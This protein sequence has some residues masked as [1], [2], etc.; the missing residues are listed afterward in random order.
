MA[1]SHSSSTSNWYLPPAATGN[2]FTPGP[3]QGESEAADGIPF[4]RAAAAASQTLASSVHCAWMPSSSTSTP[5]SFCKGL[6]R[7]VPHFSSTGSIFLASARTLGNSGARACTLAPPRCSSSASLRCHSA[8]SSVHWSSS[9]LLRRAC[10]GRYGAK[11]NAFLFL[12]CGPS[13]ESWASSFSSRARCAGL[14]SSSPSSSSSSSS[15]SSS[16]SSASSSD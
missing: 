13:S 7:Q 9:C 6:K 11:A 1:L 15:I 8:F 14:S 4:D 3:A 5:R 16:S 12:V 2:A 10:G